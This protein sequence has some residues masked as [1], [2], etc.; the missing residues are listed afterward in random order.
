M[1]GIHRNP[2]VESLTQAQPEFVKPI[3]SYLD[4]AV[5]PSRVTHGQQA[6]A[7]QYTFLTGL[8]ARTG[9]PKEILVSIWGNETAYGAGLGEFNIFEAL[10]TLAL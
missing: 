10:A 4:S 6:L 9:V 5:S 7:G 3:W 2:K 1:A 8:E